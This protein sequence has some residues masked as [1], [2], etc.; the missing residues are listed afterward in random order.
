M[1]IDP[2][3]I[4]TILKILVQLGSFVLKES[5]MA[6]QKDAMIRLTLARALASWT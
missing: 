6:L 4:E 3:V 1:T 2:M 5:G